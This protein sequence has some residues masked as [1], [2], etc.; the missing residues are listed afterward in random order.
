MISKTQSPASRNLICSPI[1]SHAQVAD[2]FA[3]D[4]DAA[5]VSGSLSFR[6][7]VP[8]ETYA[9]GYGD[10]GAPVPGGRLDFP[11]LAAGARGTASGTR[12][13]LSGV[14]SISLYERLFQDSR[15]M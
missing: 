5:G 12:P 15:P 10:D 1:S 3:P 14:R 2:V 4:L 9:T 7:H 13:T 8:G 6:A 11:P